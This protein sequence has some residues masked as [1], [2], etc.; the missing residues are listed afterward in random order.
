MAIV[1]AWSCLR[2][3]IW[4]TVWRAIVVAALPIAAAPSHAQTE[5]DGSAVFQ[6]ANGPDLDAPVRRVSDPGVVT[7]HQKIS[8]AGI[9]S[10]FAGRIFGITF[11]ASSNEVYVA[12]DTWSDGYFKRGA[13][14]YRL[15]WRSNKVLDKV[16][17]DD[18]TAGLQGLAYDSRSREIYMTST[19]KNGVELISQASGT[20]Q[21][22]SLSLEDKGNLTRGAGTGEFRDQAAQ[23]AVST[24]SDGD[25]HIGVVALTRADQAAILDLNSRR[26]LFKVKTGIAPYGVAIDTMHQTAWVSNW[27]GRFPHP[28]DVTAMIGSESD[29][30]RIVVDGRGI[31]AS[32]TVSRIDIKTAKVTADIEVGLHPTSIAL[33]EARDRL[34]VANSNSDTISVI[35][36]KEN[37]VLETINLQPF[38]HDVAGISPESLALSKDGQ[39]LYVACSGINAVAVLGLTGRHMKVE[40]MIPTGWYP[41][42]LALSQDGKYIA[43]GTLLGVGSGVGNI[44]PTGSDYPIMPENCSHPTD[45]QPNCKDAYK[46]RG[47]VYIIPAL[48][49]S[50]LRKDAVAVAANSHMQLKSSV[51]SSQHRPSANLAIPVPLHAGDPS[52][53]QHVIYIIKEN[54]TF[55]EFFG[56]LGRGNGDPSL[57]MYSED[58][59]PNQRK[60]EREFVTLDNFYAT[61]NVDSVDGHQWVTQANETDY[62]YMRGFG[63]R[64]MGYVGDDP[65]AGAR[66]G[67]IWNAV[68]DAKKTVIDFG[69]YAGSGGTVL[70]PGPA[71]SMSGLG[72]EIRQQLL[73][74]FQGGSNFDGSISNRAPND[75]LNPYLAKD[76]PGFNLD[77]PDVARARIFLRHLNE[78]EEHNDMPDLAIVQLPSDHTA[79][80]TPGFSTPRACIADNDYALGLMVD[81]VSHSKYWKSTLILVVEDDPGGDVDHVDGHRIAAWAISPYIK[82]GSVDSTFYSHP[83][84]LKTIEL[85][86]GLNNLSLFDLIAN[87]MRNSFQDTPDLRPYTVEVPKQ[88][89]Y[90]T[91][92]PLQ[93]VS[94]QTRKDAEASLRMNF[95][96][97]DAAPAAELSRILWRASKGSAVP[98]PKVTHAVFAPYSNDLDDDGKEELSKGK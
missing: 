59:I 8:P 87:D 74:E 53:I 17:K 55:D 56:S 22:A 40:G 84:M 86:L 61:G 66:G 97:P 21:Q 30:E 19:S 88:S 72:R 57:Q 65:M 92:P 83:S 23:V 46:F 85:I 90:E 49:S 27:G 33:D 63:G 36:T 39:H 34:Y 16:V 31:A 29:E 80:M 50:Q 42:S 73:Q 58:V 11:G 26:V 76:Y 71:H 51:I 25:K 20:T 79:S 6:S 43:V 52:P 95:T 78:W 77:V 48:D 70:V 62:S 98:Y 32:G 41:D 69:E 18:F 54:H 89:I 82:R 93:A 1:S 9:Q 96:V 28:G 67:F 5:H 64:N 38:T 10:V 15:D 24:G 14:L 91:N 94:G 60:I 4:R 68:T 3:V 81:A 75:S 12:D 37:A 7:T 45:L 35:D 2:I 47:A 44:P 13:I